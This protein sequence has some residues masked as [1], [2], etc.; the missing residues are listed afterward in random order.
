MKNSLSRIITTKKAWVGAFYLCFM[1]ITNQNAFSTT[2]MVTSNADAGAGTLRQAIINA[3]ANS[4][5]DIINFNF[6]STTTIT[7]TSCQ[8]QIT[9][10]VTIDGYSNP[11]SGVG[12]LMIQII[13]PTGCNI[14]YLGP[15]SDGSTIRG[16]VISGGGGGAFGIA[17]YR[18][19]GH[20]ITG[21]YIGTNITGTAAYASPLQDCINIDSTTNVTIGGT[22]G[23]IDRN[24][25]AGATAA[26]I[27]LKRHSNG[28]IIINNYIGTDTT[29]NVNIA[30]TGNGV[31]GDH[32]HNTLIGGT[33]LAERN[34]IS[35]NGSNGIYLNFCQSPVVKGNVLGM[36]ANGTTMMP[37]VGSGADIE[38]TGTIATAPIIGGP[39]VAERNYTSCNHSFGI[40][41]RVAPGTIIQNNWIGV[42]MATGLLDYGNWDAGITATNT[43]DIQCLGNVSSG[44]GVTSIHTGADGISIFS[45]SPRPIIKG[46]I[47]GLG[48]D[49][50]TPLQNVGHGI[51][52]LTCDDGI[53]GGT[54]LS[55]RNLISNTAGG[56]GIQLTPSPRV[57]VINNYI[58]TDIT[59]LVNNGG[60]QLGIHIDNSPNVEIG[61]TSAGMG[62][63]ISG[64]AQYGISINGTSSAVLVK[65]NIIGLG[66]DGVTVIKNVQGGIQVSPSNTANNSV[67]GGS[68][69]AER[70][71]ISGNGSDAVYIGG[72]STG[73]S[74]INNYIG[75]DITGTVSKGNAGNGIIVNTGGSVTIDQNVIASNT[76]WGINT[77]NAS[78]NI[79]TRN[80]IGT[81]VNGT[82]KFG[83]GKEGVYFAATS[84]TNILGGSLANANIITDNNGS[85]GVIVENNA[86]KNTITYN[87]IYCNKGPGITLQSAANESVPAPTIL[88]SG[89]NSINGTGVVNDVIHVYRNVKADG[90]VKCDCEGEIYIGTVTVASDGTWILTHGLGLS[91]AEA[92]STTATQTTPNGSTSKFTPCTTPL[93]VVLAYF[94][95]AK[96]KDDQT[97][98]LSW[99]TSSEKN[100]N[101]FEILRSDD[102]INFQVIGTVVSFGNSDKIT[103]YSFTDVSPIDGINYY[104]L[105]QVDYNGESSYSVI[106]TVDLSNYDLSIVP[107]EN[108]FKILLP[109]SQK[110]TLNYEVYSMT[111]ALVAKGTVAPSGL[112]SATVK[113]NLSAALY[114]VSVSSDNNFVTKK[115][116]ISE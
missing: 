51:E 41:V 49:G 77:T 37:N 53:I 96:N 98:S 3:N 9:D 45:T 17:M 31:D 55:E 106:R 34:V 4:G 75:T 108:G 74:V 30:N 32:S 116:L 85:A 89:T 81:D 64:N 110:S 47:I 57:K 109:G 71:I 39:T 22:G 69:L 103:N 50:K 95:A 16:L 99:T 38:N 87:S 44:N 20:F 60:L 15:G 36:G 86:Q 10:P 12:N 61:G 1:L 76:G 26:G 66:S 11:G 93:P 40:V 84:L 28:A 2:Y 105:K 29:G 58:G 52:C 18:S 114:V 43:S 23:R 35:G 21:N 72:G 33:T 91:T 19:S 82:Q 46:N 56:H 8:Q 111:G 83:N 112:S 78:N 102:G 25:I 113:L 107:S 80:N 79:I 48:I 68:T 24:I 14:F 94:N 92:A 115:I 63:I 67:I 97:V 42:D 54:L 73:H 88:F 70:N 104:K 100:N 62:N 13:S 5:A 59:G 65:G 90:G 6:A 7:L 101:Y 27:R